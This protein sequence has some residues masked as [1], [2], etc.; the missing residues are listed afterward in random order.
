M[1]ILYNTAVVLTKTLFGGLGRLSVKGRENVPR[2]G[3]FIVVA[4]HLSN[5]DPPAMVASIPR[6]LHIMAKKSLFAGSIIT[7]MLTNMGIH[8]LERG[9]R[10]VKALI[11]AIH[12][13][14]HGEPVL[15]FPE[16]T[17]SKDTK[18]HRGKTGAAYTALKA[19]APILPVG[20]IGTEH[21]PNLASVLFPL[22]RMHVNIGE[23]F[24]LPEPDGRVTQ[25]LLEQM[26]DIIMERIAVLLPEEYRGYY[27][28]RVRA[29]DAGTTGSETS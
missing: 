10:D 1:N 20:I 27:A 28:D 11:W 24:T 29:L 12:V 13:L 18:L 16:G 26:T 2:E 14:K 19:H 3:P 22:C 15:L 25:E 7:R 17:R 5:G 8:P 9:G 21:I 4:N 6:H 23:T